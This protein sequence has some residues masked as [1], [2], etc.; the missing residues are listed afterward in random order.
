VNFEL[1]TTVMDL[2]LKVFVKNR[3]QFNKKRLNLAYLYLTLRIEGRI[4]LIVQTCNLNLQKLYEVK[5]PTNLPARCAAAD[6]RV[7]G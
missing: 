5:T 6:A 4:T 1:R 7:G 2:H 3:Q